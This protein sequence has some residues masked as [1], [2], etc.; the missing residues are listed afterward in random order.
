MSTLSAWPEKLDRHASN[1]CKSLTSCMNWP[2]CLMKTQPYDQHGN[3]EQCKP[4]DQHATIKDPCS[5]ITQANWMHN[6]NDA[7]WDAG[8]QQVPSLEHDATQ[9]LMQLRPTQSEHNTVHSNP[10][11]E[12]IL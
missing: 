8:L 9:D 6:V 2:I 1:S 10:Q 11:Q 7:G 3:S 12:S 5:T 4:G